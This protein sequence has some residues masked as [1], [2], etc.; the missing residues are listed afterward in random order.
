M[1]TAEAQLFVT[2]VRTWALSRS[3]HKQELG[4]KL[5]DTF[6]PSLA[7]LLRNTPTE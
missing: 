7:V 6:Q 3:A 1:L 5:Q 2:G 4:E